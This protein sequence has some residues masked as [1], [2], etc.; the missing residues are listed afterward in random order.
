[1]ERA[2]L[3]SKIRGAQYTE[4]GTDIACA[5]RSNNKAIVLVVH[6]NLST[7]L[8]LSQW[9]TNNGFDCYSATT[10]DQAM[11]Y[12][13]KHDVQ[14]VV[15]EMNVSDSNEFSF[16]SCI[17][18]RDEHLGVIVMTDGESN[19]V[20]QAIL[21]GAWG[22][23]VEPVQR[24]EFLFHINAA[25][26]R[27]RLILD[28]QQYTKHLEQQIQK[29]M[30]DIHGAYEETIYRLVTASR[31]RDEETGAH[32]H[33]TGLCSAVLAKAAGWSSGHVRQIGLAAPMHDI[34]KIGIPDI[35]L[36]KRSPLIPSEIEIMRLHAMIGAG[37]LQGSRS[38]IL[39]MAE[40]IAR[41][42][43]EYWD[44]SG[45][46]VGLAGY[47]IPECARMV[48][49][50]D[51][52]DALTHDR[53]Y[54]PAMNKNEAL[55][56]LCQGRGSQFDPDL[57]DLFLEQISA[58]EQIAQRNPDRVQDDVEFHALAGLSTVETVAFC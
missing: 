48:A 40:Q 28:N 33:R 47:A 55:K 12:L 21:R 18:Q 23:L 9:I 1:M 20:R 34:G 43:H 5:E 17:R 27:R 52:F 46:P 16:L 31:Y 6:N 13:E 11:V 15:A 57:L 19:N 36:R 42:H 53:I 4:D 10:V 26:E 8:C 38:P 56:I 32:I 35:V 29:Q 45:Y 58:I 7:G 2:M 39:R 50:V 25:M 3:E 22:H 41:C 44:G 49:I 14:V 24:D 51:V 54:R 37:M 30:S